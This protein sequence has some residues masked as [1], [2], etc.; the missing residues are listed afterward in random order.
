VAKIA[1]IADAVVTRLNAGSYGAS[2]TAARAYVPTFKLEDLATLRVSVVIKDWS[3]TPVARRLQDNR[4]TI[5]IGVQQRIDPADTAAVD[6][7]LTLCEAIVD[8]FLGD[9]RLDSLTEVISA[10]IAPVYVPDHMTTDRVFTSVITLTVRETR[11][12]GG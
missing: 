12:R 6:A 1:D 11:T 9:T 10:A 3:G 2:F 5:D 4:H 7:L 8:D